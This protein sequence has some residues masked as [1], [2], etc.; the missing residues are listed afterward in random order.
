MRLKSSCEPLG[1][2]Y[3]EVYH[4]GIADTNVIEPSADGVAGLL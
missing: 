2:D 1:V 3:V 4:V